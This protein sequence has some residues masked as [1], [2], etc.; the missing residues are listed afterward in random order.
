MCYSNNRTK[1]SD[2][3]DI[4]RVM[5]PL[6]LI[7][8]LV[9]T[10]ETVVNDPEALTYLFEPEHSRDGIDGDH[11]SNKV[12]DMAVGKFSKNALSELI[13]LAGKHNLIG[14]GGSID[15]LKEF[16]AGGGGGAGIEVRCD[17][18]LRMSLGGG[19]GIGIGQQKQILQEDSLEP[20]Q[21][22]QQ[23]KSLRDGNRAVNRAVARKY[24]RD[25]NNKKISM[26]HVTSGAGF[27]AGVQ[28]FDD[29]GEMI[30][31]I[32]G[33]GGASENIKYVLASCGS[34]NSQSSCSS[35][36]PHVHRTSGSHADDDSFLRWDGVEWHRKT[37]WNS[38]T[39]ARENS[40]RPNV[41]TTKGLIL[42]VCIWYVLKIN[43][44][45]VLINMYVN[46]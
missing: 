38:T 23:Q 7:Q 37:G 4:L 16:G 33:G 13:A 44:V 12:S 27:G 1:S 29:R 5:W 18:V 3:D 35:L 10:L 45:H 9:K 19:G 2:D 41:T 22:Q 36:P 6:K 20:I 42:K 25:D 30:L 11:S 24:T 39:A 26:L 46:T 14:F 32:G 34:S 21:P 15:S 28:V 8:Y 43:R 40:F 31:S 17:G